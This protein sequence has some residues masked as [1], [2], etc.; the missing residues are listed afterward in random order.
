MNRISEDVSQVRMYLGPGVMYTANLIALFPLVL[1]QMLKLDV[2][3]TLF[4]LIPLPIMAILIYFVSNKMTK[5]SKSVQEEQSRLN[6]IAQESFSG[7]RVIKAYLQ[8]KHTNRLFE[9]SSNEYLRR[10]MRSVRMN[11]LFMPTIMLLIGV[12]S[13]LNVYIGGMLALNGTIEVALIVAFSMFIYKMTWP[14]ASVGW[15][16]S[17]NRRAAA[18]QARINEFLKTEPDIKVDEGKELTNFESIKFENV[19]FR[20]NPELPDTLSNLNFEL[21]KG[22]VLGIIG[23]T[24]S[25][26]SSLL[27]LLLRQTDPTQG[28][29]WVG[30]DELKKLKLSSY[31]KVAAVVPQ[32]VFLFSDTIKNNILFGTNRSDV[33][34]KELERV[35]LDAHVLHNINDF[36]DK[37]ETILGE[38]GVNLSG[39]QK[40]RVSIARALIRKPKLLILDD[41]LSAVDT[42]TEEIILS[43]LERYC[44]EFGTTV[45]IVSHRISSIRN[46]NHVLVLEDGKIVEQGTKEELQEKNGVFAEISAQQLM[47]NNSVSGFEE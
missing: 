20:Y 5:L 19:S 33:D 36:P 18:S 28:K 7:M 47:E 24:G 22:Q 43:N 27:K 16:T 37:F 4:V 8:E 13:L 30:Q 12:S 14:F 34:S 1:Y 10:Q 38:R 45:V 40:Q 17:I 2:T 32:D 23:R 31:R 39:G 25:G 46:A 41:C 9:N 29:I 21:H 11:N 42:E 3:L 26:K 35:A 15:V 44:K 6:T